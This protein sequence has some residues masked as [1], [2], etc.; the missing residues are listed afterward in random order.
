MMILHH[1]PQTVKNNASKA[2]APVRGIHSIVNLLRHHYTA[3]GSW[4][5]TLVIALIA[6]LITAIAV[7]ACRQ[8]RGGQFFGNASAFLSPAWQVSLFA[9]RQDLSPV[10][11]ISARPAPSGLVLTWP[12]LPGMSRR[13]RVCG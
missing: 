2:E 3:S 6:T 10:R 5:S 11:I 13:D 7:L 4:V 1:L 12:T 9:P 8:P